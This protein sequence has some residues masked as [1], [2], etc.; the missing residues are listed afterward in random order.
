[1]AN[2]YDALLAQYYTPADRRQSFFDSLA[3]LGAGLIAAGAPTTNPAGFSQGISQGLLGMQQTMRQGEQDAL[4]RY[5]VSSQLATADLQRQQMQARLDQ[6]ARLAALLPGLLGSGAPTAP[7]PGPVSG[8][9]VSAGPSPAPAPPPP[10]GGAV[11]PSGALP[12]PSPPPMAG[13]ATGGRS[14]TEQASVLTQIA[15]VMMPT[16]PAQ[17]I[18]LLRMAREFDPNVK[19]EISQAGEGYIRGPDGRFYSAPGLDI[20]RA[21]RAGLVAGSEAGARNASELQFAGPIAA[22]REQGKNQGAVSLVTVPGVGPLPG[23]QAVAQTT[24]AGKATGS[25]TPVQTPWGIMPAPQAAETA[26][27]FAGQRIDTGRPGF[28]MTEVPPNLGAQ[29]PAPTR[30]ERNS[31]GTFGLVLPGASAPPPA[32]SRVVA[33][34]PNPDPSTGAGR[35]QVEIGQNVAKT[36]ESMRDGASTAANSLRTL[37]VAEELLNKGVIT[38]TGANFRLGF[39]R[40]LATAGLTSNDDVAN[41]EAFVATMGRVTLDLVKQLGAGSGISNADREYA[42]NIAGGSIIVTEK[43]I[44]RLID[45]NKRAATEM[46]TRYNRQIEPIIKD[47]RTDST[48]RSQLPVSMPTQAAPASTPNNLPTTPA[49]LGRL[50]DDEVLKRLGVR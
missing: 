49:E 4:R 22:A 41:T 23:T 8:P 30:V 37:Q 18:A 39:A 28:Q 46:I 43:G 20:A 11:A 29:P 27:N 7:T 33:Q 44:R 9:P 19:I 15:A 42:Q 31:N 21:R 36:V 1:M 12:A 24:E 2:A 3:P 35:M 14:L 26:K 6:Q 16:E 32:Q 13:G 10:A 25:M 47:S 40:A 17:G 34:N 38:G 50:S 48:I 5:A 45:I